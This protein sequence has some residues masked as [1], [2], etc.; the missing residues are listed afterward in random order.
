MDD[1]LERVLAAFRDLSPSQR[2]EF[3][4][5]LTTGV[6]RGD[7]VRRRRPCRSWRTRWRGLI[8]EW[9]SGRPEWWRCAM[10]TM[11]PIEIVTFIALVGDRGCAADA[12]GFVIVEAARRGT[13]SKPFGL[14]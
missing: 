1:P 12:D 5:R 8:C 10:W 6:G 2:R 4:R 13:E 3:L 14:L 7:P 9:T 11:K